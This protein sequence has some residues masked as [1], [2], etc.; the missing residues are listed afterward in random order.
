IF[1]RLAL[2]GLG[3]S[4][5]TSPNNAAALNAVP[6]KRRGIA[7]ALIATARN[8]GM[9]MGIAMAGTV[10][11]ATYASVYPGQTLE[12]YNL[13]YVEGFMTAFHRAMFCGGLAA[14][15]GAVFSSLRGEAPYPE[16]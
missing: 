8:M 4:M 15:A 2:A 11:A 6:G 10:F 3:T 12:G 9:V 7:S 1:W 5:F 14:A 16:E 13:Q